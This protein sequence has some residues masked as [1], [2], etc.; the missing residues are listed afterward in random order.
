MF[1]SGYKGGGK[2]LNGQYLVYGIFFL[3]WNL[4]RNSKIPDFPNEGCI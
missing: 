4:Q 2:I 1:I 3:V